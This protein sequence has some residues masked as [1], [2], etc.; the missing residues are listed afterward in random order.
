M[1]K[2]AL[3]I[4]L[5][6]VLI[7]DSF[8]QNLVKNPSFEGGVKYYTGGPINCDT[9]LYINNWT[10]V[11]GSPDYFNSLFNKCAYNDGAGGV[12]KNMYGYAPTI[13][14]N[15]YFALA[16]CGIDTIHSPYDWSWRNIEYIEG[17]L[18]SPLIQGKK[19]CASFY[20]RLVDS[21]GLATWS[22]GVYLSK[23]FLPDLN[24]HYD[25][26]SNYYLHFTP[27]IQNAEGNFLKDTAWVKIEGSFI[28][29]GNEKYIIIG[30]FNPYY[31][32]NYLLKTNNIID[33]YNHNAS[34]YYIDMVSVYECN[35]TIVP[36][37]EIKNAL[38]IPNIFSPNQDGANDILYLRGEN[39]KDAT[40]SIYNRWGEKVFESNDITKGWDGSYKG[41]PCP[42]EVYVYSCSVT[43]LNGE[44]KKTGG[45]I[46]L[47]R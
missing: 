29:E 15:G 22:I 6:F 28:A 38:Y 40:I 34:L 19:Y 2:Q 31:R 8:S 3:N 17:E 14:G 35:D 39:I 33:Y 45:N 1:I 30:N 26:I 20:A 13:T 12:P 9:S 10:V 25:T 27:Q 37:P 46:T 42:A 36:L 32:K 11:L 7:T 43:F 16:L 18:I 47:V 44:I 21:S 5:L 41:K 23:D 4:I 24:S